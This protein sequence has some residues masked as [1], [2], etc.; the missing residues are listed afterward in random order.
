MRNRL[1]GIET[2]Y[3][4]TIRDGGEWSQDAGLL[5]EAAKRRLP[6]MAAGDGGIFLSNGGRFY[7]DAGCHPEFSTPEV[8]SPWD[9]SRF[10]K[11]GDRVVLDSANDMMREN[12]SLQVTLNRGGFCYAEGSASWA[13]HESIC[14]QVD[15][16]DLLRQQLVPHLVSRQ[17]F[18]GGGGFDNRSPG[19][20][21]MISPR[22]AHI[23]R[24]VGHASQS[25][26][27]IYHTKEEPLCDGFSRLH[28]IC[29]ETVCSELSQWL[30]SATTV[31]VVALIEIGACPIGLLDGVSELAAMRR[32]SKDESLKQRTSLRKR[33]SLTAIQI[34]RSYLAAV[35][36]RRNDPR[37]PDWTGEACEKWRDVLD[38]LETGSLD[39]VA[40][41]LDWAIKLK[42]YRSFCEDEG[43]PWNDLGAW[44]W[45]AGVVHKA[46]GVER[47]SPS[48]REAIDT[49]LEKRQLDW[50]G[51]PTFLATRQKL[52]ELDTRF[53]QLGDG[54]FD[55]LVAA[56]VLD[57]HVEGV[58]HIE[59]AVK[60]PP[61]GVTRAR[62]RGKLILELQSKR[63][64]FVCQW[65]G[66]YDERKRFEFGDPYC[67]Q[68]VEKTTEP[69]TSQ[70][71]FGDVVPAAISRRPRQRRRLGVA[72]LDAIG[73]YVRAGQFRSAQAAL[74]RMTPLPAADW[75]TEVQLL[76]M[77][78]IVAARLAC[79]PETSLDDSAFF[80]D[81]DLQSVCDWLE[82]YRFGAISPNVGRLRPFVAQGIDIARTRDHECF[83][84]FLEHQAAFAILDDRVEDVAGILSGANLESP[85]FFETSAWARALA[86][87]GESSRRL[88]SPSQARR[89]LRQAE[90]I[91]RGNNLLSDFVSITV[92]S[93]VKLARTEQERRDYLEEALQLCRDQDP[94]GEVRIRLLQTRLLLMPSFDIDEH[95]RRIVE[96]RADLPSLAECP[97]L[98]A[99]LM[100]WQDWVGPS[101]AS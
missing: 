36:S 71:F 53:G 26:R 38:Q 37:M 52:F 50:S 30:K 66:I 41:R 98:T 46:G 9:A 95:R 80:C 1:T 12:P 24:R 55:S 92:P 28:I 48:D 21:F 76:R 65:N 8:A 54:L 78:A 64:S 10:I 63:D 90:E 72:V 67:D 75:E 44:N 57:Q 39:A 81:D 47:I 77:Q 17:I 82:V 51:F 74:A 96:L 34:Q 88:N 3:A 99:T 86:T 40:T 62:V 83:G 32:I 101:R 19:L 5:I 60:S 70:T 68:A 69:P 97:E 27:P 91:Q 31:L 85:S 84:D 16:R 33:T 7:I 56:G 87:L 13:C 94:I 93:L 22:V 43:I 11:A 6:H 42:L 73:D 61:T 4:C 79:D 49:Y 20:E 15:D 89:M 25:Q 14:H 2:E 100:R 58:D 29:G 35:E 59:D 23:R 45:V 18:T